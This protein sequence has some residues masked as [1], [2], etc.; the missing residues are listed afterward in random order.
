MDRSKVTDVTQPV[1]FFSNDGKTGRL[2][3]VQ[4]RGRNQCSCG[5]EVLHPYA[6]VKIDF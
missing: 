1:Q 5:E 2:L 6:D 3:Q 4:S